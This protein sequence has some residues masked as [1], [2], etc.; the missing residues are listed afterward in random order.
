MKQGPRTPKKPAPANQHRAPPSLR[1]PLAAPATPEPLD[2]G[3]DPRA[4]PLRRQ[5]PSLRPPGG[6]CCQL[7]SLNKRPS[8]HGLTPAP[9]TTNL[10]PLREHA[11]R[12][13][14]LSSP[15][16]PS[17]STLWEEA[18]PS[19]P[20]N[21][22]SA[23]T[24]SGR[25][26]LQLGFWLDGG[27]GKAWRTVADSNSR[28]E[29]GKNHRALEGTWASDTRLLR[30]MYDPVEVA[31]PVA[32]QR[33][34]GRPYPGVALRAN[35][36][37]CLGRGRGDRDWRRR[38]LKGDAS[39]QEEAFFSSEVP[40]ATSGVEEAVV[41]ELCPLS[42]LAI[43]CTPS[44]EIQRYGSSGPG[45]HSSFL[46]SFGGKPSVPSA[47]GAPGWAQLRGRDPVTPS[48]ATSGQRPGGLGLGQGPP[49]AFASGV[50]L[51]VR[52][53]SAG[54]ARGWGAQSSPVLVTS[55]SRAVGDPPARV[56]HGASRPAPLWGARDPSC[57]T[58]TRHRGGR[59][60][61]GRRT[62][63]GSAVES[64]PSTGTG[65][66]S[67]ARQ[68]I[69]L[70]NA[71]NEISAELPT[72]LSS[73]E[74]SGSL[75]RTLRPGDNAGRQLAR[76]P[77][78][79]SNPGTQRWRR[80]PGGRQL[81][82]E[83]RSPAEA[84]GQ[85]AISVS[86]RREVAARGPRES[87]LS[88][89]FQRA[90][91]KCSRHRMHHLPPQIRA[92]MGRQIAVRGGHAGFLVPAPSARLPGPPDCVDGNVGVRAGVSNKCATREG[93]CDSP[94]TRTLGMYAECPEMVLR[95]FGLHPGNRTALEG[96]T[97]GGGVRV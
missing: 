32:P 90:H 94:R 52:G 16:Q 53:P 47:R 43:F 97:R 11:P 42:H 54:K 23:T 87:R 26:L 30:V 18:P 33:G 38:R 36:P 35:R 14:W 17:P 15:G 29:R 57:S 40:E 84:S 81:D 96:V 75:S 89:P 76:L 3:T 22:V 63:A 39:G 51:T 5:A 74:S 65:L 55:V 45:K 37:N 10:A 13:L 83:C 50:R 24:H 44:P 69:I 25:S 67:P 82:G 2:F 56:A 41:S 77:Y 92:L 9:V 62:R 27:G 70:L 66:R 80:P 64:P 4:G 85:A 59:H 28:V 31:W 68:L 79:S 72:F 71:Y 7:T 6:P 86:A 21:V 46:P 60:H 73:P 34:R 19:L 49:P 78:S 93:T 12:T 61:R 1:L 91:N 48:Q 20:L 88:E 58:S 8:P 95:L